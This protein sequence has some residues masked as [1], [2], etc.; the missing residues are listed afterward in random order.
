MYLVYF[1]TIYIFYKLALLVYILGFLFIY[2]CVIVNMKLEN[3]IS[4]ECLHTV[5]AGISLLFS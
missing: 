5:I 1:C 3:N 4:P 2:E